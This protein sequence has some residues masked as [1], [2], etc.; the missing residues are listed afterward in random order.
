M[1]FAFGIEIGK[2]GY[3]IDEKSYF[4]HIQFFLD[5]GQYRCFRILLSGI[6]ILR[7]LQ[8]EGSAFRGL[9]PMIADSLPDMFGNIFLRNGLNRSLWHLIKLVHWISLVMF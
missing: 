6:N 7:Y 2:L 4:Q 9:P 8:Y 3:D 5:S 1:F